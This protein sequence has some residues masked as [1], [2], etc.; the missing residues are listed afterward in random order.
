MSF[1]PPKSAKI[2]TKI[3]FLVGNHGNSAHVYIYNGKKYYCD[4]VKF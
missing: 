1:F 2:S 4:F 3:G